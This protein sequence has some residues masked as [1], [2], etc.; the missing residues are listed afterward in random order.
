MDWMVFNWMGIENERRLERG[1]IG[2][3]GRERLVL[4]GLD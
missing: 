2:I 3:Q 1:E 4:P